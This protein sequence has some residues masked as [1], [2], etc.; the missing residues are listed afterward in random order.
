MSQCVD[1]DNVVNIVLDSCSSGPDKFSV[2]YQANVCM[3]KNI[4]CTLLAPKRLNLQ[5]T[6]MRF[7]LVHWSMD[8]SAPEMWNQCCDSVP[9]DLP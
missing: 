9:D 6:N 5:T 4:D 8:C 3:I 2:D 1:F 7:M